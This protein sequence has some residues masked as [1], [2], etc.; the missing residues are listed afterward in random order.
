ML[1][2]PKSTMCVLHIPMHL[3]SGHVTLL[4]GKFHPPKFS[5]QSGLGCRVDSGWALPQISS[6]LLFCPSSCLPF[7]PTAANHAQ[8]VPR[9]SLCC[10]TVLFFTVLKIKRKVKGR[11]QLL[12]SKPISELRSVTCH[13]GSHSVTCHPTEVNAPRLN[14]SQIGRYSIYLPWREGRLS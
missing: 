10:C 6:F 1:T 8:D 11:I 14:P 3:S 12:M 5:P 4:L 13:M 9:L 2:H 7:H